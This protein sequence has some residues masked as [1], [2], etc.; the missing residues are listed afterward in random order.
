MS[1]HSWGFVGSIVVA[2][3][4]AGCVVVPVG[5]PGHAKRSGAVVVAPPPPIVIAARPRMVFVTE[6]GVAFA[7]DLEVDVYELGGVWYTFRTGA[8][9][10]AEGYGGPWVVVKARHVPK[11]LV[12]IKP[13]QVRKAY[14]EREAKGH[15]GNRGRGMDKH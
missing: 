13:G 9:Y 4:A 7:P 12:K 8:W 2:L 11:A 15:A 3:L 10:R 5:P 1:K 6:F 14:M